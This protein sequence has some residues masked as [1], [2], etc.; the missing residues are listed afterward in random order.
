M[1]VVGGHPSHA[2]EGG[3]SIDKEEA[4]DIV[5]DDAWNVEGG[6]QQYKWN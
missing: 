6:H 1:G 3:L 5:M 4:E 2:T